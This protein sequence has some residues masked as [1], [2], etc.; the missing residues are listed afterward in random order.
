QRVDLHGVR[1]A[2]LATLV[3]FHPALAELKHDNAIGQ[4][5]HAD[6]VRGASGNRHENREDPKREIPDFHGFWPARLVSGVAPD[7]ANVAA[8]SSQFSSGSVTP[9][10]HLSG[11]FAQISLQS[12]YRLAPPRTGTHDAAAGPAGRPRHRS[13]FPASER[14]QAKYAVE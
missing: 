13:R 8:A 5:L 12:V 11:V 14:Q 10:P 7:S 4:R 1:A 6:E 2:W 3:I 9:L